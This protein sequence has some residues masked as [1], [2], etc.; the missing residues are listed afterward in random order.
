MLHAMTDKPELAARQQ[1]RCLGWM[2]AAVFFAV[3]T[4]VLATIFSD[5]WFALVALVLWFLGWNQW[6]E[7]KRLKQWVNR[8][9][10]TSGATP[11]GSL[12]CSFCGKPQEAARPSVTPSE[13]TARNAGSTPVFSR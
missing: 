11:N 7:Y 2:F 5:P 1:R 8:F 3:L 4:T 10:H 13:K 6:S 9:S 12:H